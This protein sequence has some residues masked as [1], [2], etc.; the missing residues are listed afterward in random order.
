MRRSPRQL[1]TL[2]RRTVAQDDRG[3][4]V[5]TWSNLARVW[6]DLHQLAGRERE[7]AM[8]VSSETT[9]RGVM[10]WT[11]GLTPAPKD[12][13]I[14]GTH[15]LEILAV[16]DEQERHQRLILDLKEHGA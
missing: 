8:Q 14:Y 16:M 6:M 3:Q 11:P 2:Q 4:D 12:R 13:V 5:E 9:W 15:T 7:A 1:V 10:R